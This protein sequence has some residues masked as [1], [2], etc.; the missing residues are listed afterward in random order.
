[1]NLL[2]KKLGVAIFFLLPLFFVSCEDPGKIGLNIDPKNGALLS[3]Y[4]EFILPST[5]VQFDPR[6]TVNSSSFQAGTY[7][8]PDFGVVTSMSYS[9]LGRQNSTPL[10]N[11]TAEYDSLKISVQFATI[12]GSAAIDA[13]VESLDLYQLDMAMNIDEEYNRTSEMPLGQKLGSLD[14][15]LQEMDTLQTDSTFTFR[16]SDTFGQ[17]LFD[18]LKAD[19]GTYDNDT[20]FNDYFKGIAI[21]P[22][23]SNDKI[24][25]LNINSF[26]I[27]MYYHEFNVSGDPLQRNFAYGLGNF[28]FYHIDSELGGTPMSGLQPNNTDFVPTSD[29]RYL[30][31]GTLIALKLDYSEFF[32]F[33]MADSNQNMIVQRAQLRVG[34]IVENQEGSESPVSLRGFFTDDDNTWP[35]TTDYTTTADTSDIFV[36]L[37]EDLIP[38]GNYIYPQNIT[39]D[40]I[41]TTT[42]IGQMSTFI[43][44][45]YSGGY[46][47]E[48]TPYETRG[49]L[50]LFPPTDLD[51]PQSA[52]SHVLTNYF[53][54]HKDSIRLR[55]Y[56]SVPN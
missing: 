21:V 12:Y 47:S 44:N 38:P 3:K 32:D 28:R 6:S 27:N 7:T 10:V 4:Q 50:I 49:E 52:P 13:E 42:Y 9:W 43:Q 19:D 17:E 39:F 8:D 16:L 2:V 1:M 37:Q 51:F 48:D 55:V 26:V 31:A 22:N 15:Y 18:K 5:E 11:E 46:D 24:L 54:V 41:D 29:F 33:A 23:G 40:A 45:M 56:Y 20:T 25:Q 14:F 36:Q 34:S 53:K 30:Q 35:L